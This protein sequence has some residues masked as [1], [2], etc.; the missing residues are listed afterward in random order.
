MIVT[1]FILAACVAVFITLTWP[2]IANAGIWRA[3]ITPLA[4]IIGSGFLVIG[5]ILDD[6]FGG[7]A[8]LAMLALCGLAY[9]FGSA[10]RENI[11]FRADDTNIP[12]VIRDVER[13]AS[14]ALSLAYIVSVAYYLNL[15]G[16]FAVRLTSADSQTNARLVTSGLFIIILV[17]GWRKGF[18][19]L[20]KMEQ[21]SVNIKL[22]I[23]TGLLV[24]LGFHLSDK[25]TAGELLFNTP[26]LSGW[27]SLTLVFGLLVTVQGFEISRYMG[28]EYPPELRI[29]AMRYAQLLTTAIY[30]AYIL[31]MSYVFHPEDIPLEESAII[32]MMELVAP[33]LPVMLVAA[34]LAAQF[35]AAIADTGGCG[36]LVHELTKEKVKPRFSYLA[37][38]ICGLA[39]TWFA[40]VFDIISYASR[41]FALYYALQAVETAM[42]VWYSER[43][44]GKASAYAALA[45]LGF[46]ITV[47]GQ[48]VE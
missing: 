19:A 38:T 13:A 28:R 40:D 30:M 6:A 4:S 41:V 15:F 37:V 45:G 44:A 39:L 11:G 21:V 47:F 35:S 22:A 7:Y 8:P 5:P 31:L 36:G 9:L 46:A 26:I 23:I 24:G 43:Q 25:A 29:R 10:I 18:S 3:S 1:I 42:R 34:A 17:V 33:I 2:R 16:E 27:Q 48:A 14:W 12:P 32:D 20:E